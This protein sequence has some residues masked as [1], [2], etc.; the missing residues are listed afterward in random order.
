MQK[1]L[2]KAGA[3]AFAA[4]L[5]VLAGCGG[6]KVIQSPIA[7]GAPDWV[8]KGS[9]AFK[10]SGVGVFYGVGQANN[11]QI[12][13]LKQNAADDRARAEIAKIMNTYVAVL[14]KDYM[15]SASTGQQGVSSDE[16]MVSQTLKTFAKF[17][18]NGATIV[19]HWVDQS[20]GSIFSLCKL[21]MKAIQET[22]NNAKELD[23][24]VRDYVKA[25]A[26]KAFD[27]LSG[28]EAKGH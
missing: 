24:K 7:K 11:I 28:E 22:L 3:L 5:A 12:R 20:D 2:S 21:D 13:A 1:S 14:N 6:Q 25:N 4:G 15:A 17:T 16:Q 18:L 8:N 23:A 19:D 27:E 26:E 10:G 9:G